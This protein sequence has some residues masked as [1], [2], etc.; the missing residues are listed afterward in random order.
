M[1]IS[2]AEEHVSVNQVDHK[3]LICLPLLFRIIYQQCTPNNGVCKDELCCSAWL[4]TKS[5]KTKVYVPLRAFMQWDIV[6]KC[7][8][9]G[10]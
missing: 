9:Q 5:E 3:L 7:M 10:K 4:S 8:N 1:K 2:K 6:I